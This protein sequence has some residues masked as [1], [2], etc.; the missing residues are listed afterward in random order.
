MVP[1]HVKQEVRLGGREMLVRLR[2]TLPLALALPHVC[3]E[4]DGG[5]RPAIAVLH[6]EPFVIAADRPPNLL[7]KPLTPKV[8]TRTAGAIEDA[9]DHRRG[10]FRR[11][12]IA[13]EASIGQR[14]IIEPRLETLPV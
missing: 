5:I 10:E 7:A 14:G 8:G 4:I 6:R 12:E 13:H 3:T 9:A 11:P 1:G 2:P